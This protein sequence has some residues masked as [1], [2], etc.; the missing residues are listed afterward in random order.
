MLTGSSALGECL[1][2][3]IVQ[4]GRIGQIGQIGYIDQIRQKHSLTPKV[5]KPL[6]S[7]DYYDIIRMRL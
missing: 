5:Q 2:G 4:I 7:W 3:Q 6:V 1:T